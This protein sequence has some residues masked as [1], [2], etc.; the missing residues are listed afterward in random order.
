MGKFYGSWV[1][2]DLEEP[3]RHTWAVAPMVLKYANATGDTDFADG[4]FLWG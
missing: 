2:P 4:L 1:I 3:A